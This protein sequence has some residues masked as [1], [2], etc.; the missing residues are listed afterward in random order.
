MRRLAVDR[1]CYTCHAEKAVPPSANSTL[2]SAPSWPEIARRYRGRAD[3]E[4]YLTGI[5]ISGTGKGKRHWPNEAAFASMLPND[6]EVT[7]EE[8]RSLVKWILAAPQ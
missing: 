6:A 2:P 7:P 4:D 8:A 1:G 3:A 5:V